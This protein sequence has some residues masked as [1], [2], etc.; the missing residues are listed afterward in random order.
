M[1]DL[2]KYKRLEKLFKT[3]Y[4]QLVEKLEHSIRLSIQFND[5]KR[6]FYLLDIYKD[7]KSVGIRIY[8][9]NDGIQ[10]FYDINNTNN[11]TSFDDANLE[12][13]CV[14]Y[15][16]SDEL[17]FMD[18]YILKT[19][20]KRIS[21]NINVIIE[22]FNKG[23]KNAKISEK[24]IFEYEQIIFVLKEI[25]RTKDYQ[26]LNKDVLFLLDI[27][28][29]KY[30][31]NL[32]VTNKD[33]FIPAFTYK[34]KRKND[35]IVLELSNLKRVAG[36]YSLYTSY[37]AAPSSKNGFLYFVGY[38]EYEKPF[39]CVECFE[40][41]ENNYIE[42]LWGNLIN[43]LEK[44]GLPEKLIVNDAQIYFII[45]NTLEAANINVVYERALSFSSN[46]AINIY[47]SIA[48]YAL[49]EGGQE[50]KITDVNSFVKK[51][52]E[53]LDFAVKNGYNPIK[54]RLVDDIKELYGLIMDYHKNETIIAD[55]NNFNL[56]S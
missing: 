22:C 38:G 3:I 33:E 16:K 42:Y 29:D 47:L 31:Y 35:N 10:T 14:R 11:D 34:Q 54:E 32:R 37:F 24:Q 48:S 56:V 8:P 20:Q 17:D 50:I 25:F 1:L 41:V 4:N 36:E 9:G 7:E 23:T 51:A 19:V 21:K 28:P 43:F 12:Y 44:N 46:Y 2:D 13:L 53:Y 15:V 52:N 27:N 45:K 55:S 30:Y 5:K 18:K 26:E 39:K 6:N 40:F 49:N